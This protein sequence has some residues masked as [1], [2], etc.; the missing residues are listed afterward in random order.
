MNTEAKNT[1]PYPGHSDRQRVDQ[2]AKGQLSNPK[3]TECNWRNS[4]KPTVVMG[5]EDA[6][7]NSG[8]GR[9]KRPS[10]GF[11]INYDETEP[12]RSR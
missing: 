9:K 5:S 6:T 4:A 12:D 3:P 8:P 2:D 1:D 10:K 11:D 7:A